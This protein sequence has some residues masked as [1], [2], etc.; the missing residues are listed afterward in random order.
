MTFARA[1]HWLTTTALI[2]LIAAV[3]AGRA[4]ELARDLPPPGRIRDLDYGDVL[5]HF[6]KDDYFDAIVRLEVS[7]DLGR[8]PHHAAEAE[9][10]S[11]GLYLSL[12]LHGEATRIF[13]GLLAGSVPQSV[14]D[15][16]HFYL[17]R[18]GYQRGYYDEAAASLA[19]IRAPLAGNLE[20]ERKL[21]EANVLM[22]QGRH[23][24]AAAKLQDWTDTSDWA[25][26]ARF[27]LGVALVRAG[28]T[29]RGRP[30][31]EWVG[32]REV[33]GDEQRSLRDR[34]NLALGYALLQQREPEPAALALSR[35][36]LDGP[37]TN[38]ALLGLGWAEAD[39]GRS[40]RA[41]VPWLELR[42]R[43]LLDAAV[44]ESFLAVPYAYAKLASNGQAAQH[45]QFA[46]SAYA[47][48]RRRIDE[49]IVAIQGGGFLDTILAAAPPGGDIGWLW[50]LENAPEAPHTRY[51][52]HLLASHEFQEGLRN[53]R[54]LRIMQRNL[55]RWRSS[56]EAFDAMIEARER[57]SADREPRRAAMLGRT[58]VAGLETRYSEVAAR[59]GAVA[60]ERDIVALGTPEQREQWA[61]LEQ[62]AAR[63]AS[64]PEGPKREALAERARLLRGSLLWELDSAFKLRLWKL[65]SSLKATGAA[66]A[67][68]T[69]RIGFVQT[70]S[71][72]APQNT[73]GFEARVGTLARRI[74]ELGPRIDRVTLAQEQMLA[75]V[76]V[77]ELEAQ[78][79]RLASYA[80]QAQFALASIYDGAAARSAP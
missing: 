46:V 32:T 56:L 48:E 29:E 16:A 49:S 69:Q 73:A 21:L 10:L 38:R 47:D 35:V 42:E 59:V 58:D 52:Y 62:V 24:E 23:A 65:E 57:A 72:L 2:A 41:L 22:A 44:Q 71:D 80:T 45:Y 55:E 66:L 13:N 6:F 53:Y 67:E 39:A 1:S 17:A 7:R 19:R 25:A 14:S 75:R 77:R 70:A 36:R 31:L 33:R 63:V 4:E 8:M 40:E 9:L 26:Y 54:D 64:L 74:D 51:L 78:K 50:Q 12:G 43:P 76:A 18:I 11:G 20:P 60:A 61:T 27:N 34:A 5:F 28:E 3:P 79:A 15:R 68:T 37:F 30:F